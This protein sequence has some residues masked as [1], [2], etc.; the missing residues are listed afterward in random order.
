MKQ[1]TLI[2]WFVILTIALFVLVGCSSARASAKTVTLTD[3]DAGK[4]IELQNGNLLVV[5]LD[6]NIT[7]GFNWEMVPQ[8]SAVLKQLGEPVVTPDSSALGAGG[9]ISLKFQAVKTGQASLTLIYHRSFE[10]DVPPEKTFEVTI[11]VK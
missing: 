10:K 6:G 4:T 7:T 1:K 8:T 9:K 3:A 5:T 2:R 11:L